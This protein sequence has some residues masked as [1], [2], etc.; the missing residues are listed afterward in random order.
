MN[1][2]VVE[3]W[4]AIDDEAWHFSPECP[5]LYLTD[6]KVGLVLADVVR[7]RARIAEAAGEDSLEVCA[8]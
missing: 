2:L 6:A 4:L 1:A 7:L 8:C 3:R 5:N